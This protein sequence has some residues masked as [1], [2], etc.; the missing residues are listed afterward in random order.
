MLIVEHLGIFSNKRNYNCVDVTKFCVIERAQRTTQYGQIG[1]P[2]ASE[3]SYFF[4]K[5]GAV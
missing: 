2:I 3:P 1:Q 4:T 5:L